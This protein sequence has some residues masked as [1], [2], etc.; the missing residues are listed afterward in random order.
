MAARRAIEIMVTLLILLFLYPAGAFAQV[1]AGHT[2]E[3]LVSVLQPPPCESCEET[4]AEL[5]E[6]AQLEKTRT[7]AQEAHARLDIKRSVSRF[8]EGAGI[9]FDEGRLEAC[10]P[11]FLTRRKEEKAATD[12][13]KDSFCRLRPF[14]TPGNSLHPIEDLKPDESFSY[15]SGHATWAATVGFLL[16]GMLPEKRQAI[17]SR[18][19]DY[20]RSRMIAGVHF[21]SDVEA[22]KLFGAAIASSSL[23]APGFDKEYAEA[24]SCV[25]SAVGLQ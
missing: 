18:I 8:L 11:F 19:D 6:L 9:A 15:P 4:K 17:Y 1:C 16:A 10:E 20:A 25:R 24:K 23:E 3:P 13:A 22:G 2:D 5:D 12:A 21:R 14:K 7:P